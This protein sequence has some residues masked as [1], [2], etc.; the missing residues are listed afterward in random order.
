MIEQTVKTIFEF[1]KSA[2]FT[3]IITS[4]S[5]ILGTLYLFIRPFLK[6]KTE[7]RIQKALEQARIVSSKYNDLE[8]NFIKTSKNLDFILQELEKQREALKIAFDSSNLDYSAKKEVNAILNKVVIPTVEVKKETKEVAKTEVK[9]VKKEE[10][11]KEVPTEKR[12]LF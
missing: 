11:V 9:V 4:I 1:F 10:Q 3:A 12:I 6:A 5:A 2:D 7:A 8:D